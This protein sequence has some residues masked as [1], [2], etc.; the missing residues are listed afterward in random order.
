MSA[1]ASRSAADYEEEIALLRRDLES[2]RLRASEAGAR[3]RAAREQQTATADVLAIIVSSPAKLDEVLET[4]AEKAAH[5]TGAAGAA[6]WAVEGDSLVQLAAVGPQ[7]DGHPVNV[8]MPLDRGMVLGRAILDRRTTHVDDLW[9]ERAGEDPTA[10]QIVGAP[11]HTMLGVPLVHQGTVIGGL[12]VS[13]LEVRPFTERQIRLLE[14]FAAQAVIAME[15]AR[16][17]EELEKRTTELEE[18]N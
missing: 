18:S 14:T 1:K 15:N 2:A 7:R 10:A 3:E 16:L 17:F 8:R 11:I 12:S 13:R 9:A 4:V 6:F 5:L